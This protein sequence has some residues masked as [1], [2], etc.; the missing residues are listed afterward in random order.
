MS[1]EVNGP[2]RRQ[3]N[4]KNLRNYFVVQRVCA[5]CTMCMCVYVALL[6]NLL[7]Y[8]YFSVSNATCAYNT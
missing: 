3:E 8:L 2:N 7:V 5:L 6:D 1:V 4:M